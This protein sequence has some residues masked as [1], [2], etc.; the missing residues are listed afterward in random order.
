MNARRAA[1]LV[2][3]G[4]LLMLPV[5]SCSQKAELPD[6][7][8]AQ[9]MVPFYPHAKLTDQMGSNSYGDGPEASWDGMAWWLTSTDKPEKILAFY[10]QHLSGWRKEVNDEGETTYRT[11]P[12]GAVDGEEVYVLVKPNGEIQIGESVQSNKKA[13]Q[14]QS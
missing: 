5:V 3:L 2:L 8:Y 7:Y 12:P 13:K 11:A 4:V 9:D 6:A 1:P 14:K 10:D